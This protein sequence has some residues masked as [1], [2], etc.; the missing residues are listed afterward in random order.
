M[1]AKRGE[2]NEN[3]TWRQKENASCGQSGKNSEAAD[4]HAVAVD[5]A[6]H[7]RTEKEH[8]VERY[9]LSLLIR[10]ACLPAWG[11]PQIDSA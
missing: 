3:S 10:I 8:S 7:S 4:G 9:T 6:V 2:Q 11:L 1:S 5:G